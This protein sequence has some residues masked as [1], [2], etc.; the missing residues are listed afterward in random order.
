MS[1]YKTFAANLREQC[2]RF[3]SIAHV[4]RET[5]INRQQF[6][7]YLAGQ[8]LPNART[9]A[10]LGSY[11]QIEEEQLFALRPVDA[12]SQP[13][14]AYPARAALRDIDEAKLVDLFRRTSGLK[15][16]LQ[17]GALDDGYYFLYFC[18]HKLPG[19][20][21]RTVV[22]VASSETATYFVRHT[23][24]RSNL[25]QLSRVAVGKHHGMVFGNSTE[26]YLVG[27]NGLV[28]AHLSAI[29]LEK[30]QHSRPHIL[31]GVG[32]TRGF[33][34]PFASR[35]CL[36]YIGTGRKAARF[37]LSRVGATPC[38][39]EHVGPAVACAM[40]AAAQDLPGQLTLLQQDELIHSLAG[41]HT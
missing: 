16:I 19:Q 1:V 21:M 15:S 8:I 9:L 18:L 11:F 31:C 13:V 33:S 32:V 35:V 41:K 26:L 36:E 29:A 30:V 3:P 38:D 27:T 12:S 7:K 5:G 37:A 40:S 28:P 6:S 23:A 20:L 34:Q 24:L 10:K 25:N 2:Q 4:C 22:K 39:A 17:P 14:T